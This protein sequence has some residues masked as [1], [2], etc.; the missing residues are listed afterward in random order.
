[1]QGRNLPKV[2]LDVAATGAGVLAA[3]ARQA[4]RL[5]L[6]YGADTDRIAHAVKEAREI[7][8]AAGKSP[9]SLTF[10]TY[11]PIAP[12]PDPKVARSL[13]KGVAAVYAR[14]QAMPGHQTDQTRA[15]DR[16]VIEAV[17]KNYDNTAHGRSDARHTA[18]LEDNFL[19]RFTVVGTPDRCVE[20][21][22]GLSK[23]GLDRIMLV[24]PNKLLEGHDESRRLL[25]EVVLPEVRRKLGK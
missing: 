18:Y 16:N 6:N 11:M 17:G 3:G 15:A 10:G 9:E 25:A 14:F 8:R 21:L 13:V 4:E 12:H 24:G 22:V 20:Q 1:M 19:D 23:A 2:P 7:R 5:S